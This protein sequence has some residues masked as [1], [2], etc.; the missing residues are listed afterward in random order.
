M[1]SHLFSECESNNDFDAH[2][3]VTGLFSVNVA[4]KDGKWI[5]SMLE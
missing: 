1:M 4:G 3:D 2:G 5:R